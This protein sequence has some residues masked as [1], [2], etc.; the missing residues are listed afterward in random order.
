MSFDREFAG[1]PV[2][3]IC[4]I[5][6]VAE[7]CLAIRYGAA[8]LGLVSA[9][10]S[11]PGEIPLA[12]IAAIAAAVPPPVATFL[13]T[14]RVEPGDIIDQHRVARTGVIQLCDRL[15][16]GGYG[17]LRRRLPGIKLVQVV[18]VQNDDAVA[19][20]LSIQ[21]W[22]DAILLDSGNPGAEIRELGGTGRIHD[23][24]VSRRIVTSLDIPVFLAGGLR[25][26][27]V[28]R[29]V[30]KVRP[31]GVDVCSGLRTGGRLDESRLADFFRSLE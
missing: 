13:L 8:A 29:A 23:W 27:N 21:T 30:S 15:V 22:V 31:F 3:K 24:S 14:S 5:A 19:E 16:E 6:D 11:G 17:E 4:C 2:V 18:H 10:P 26:D 25:P 9:M 7:A 28:A 1:R 20:A 12:T